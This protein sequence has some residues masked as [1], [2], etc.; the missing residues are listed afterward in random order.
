MT[1][2][3]GFDV[4][5]HRRE[6]GLSVVLRGE[7]DVAQALHL[8]EHFRKLEDEIRAREE[9]DNL[10]VID[11]RELTFIDSSGIRALIG[12]SQRM[13]AE[14]AEVVFIP[15][16]ENIRRVFSITGVDKRLRFVKEPG[17]PA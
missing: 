13:R 1:N 17:S 6:N 2:G 14:A 12:A 4:E 10:V 8:R 15:G 7:L 9:E 3:S 5:S 16:P 11:L